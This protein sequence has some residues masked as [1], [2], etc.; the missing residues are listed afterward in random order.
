M[1]HAHQDKKG[2]RT[3]IPESFCSTWNVR[4]SP[5]SL[6]ALSDSP[7]VGRSIAPPQSRRRED[8][9]LAGID[10]R[11][12][13]A[14]PAA[15]SSRRRTPDS[16]ASRPESPASRLHRLSRVGQVLTI[17]NT[18]GPT[19]LAGSPTAVEWTIRP[20]FSACSSRNRTASRDLRPESRAREIDASAARTEKGCKANREWIRAC[21]HETH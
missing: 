21:R 1:I 20:A 11:A 12:R 19:S 6:S 4:V 2:I 18:G 5:T 13:S 7:I 9:S 16:S 10:Q 17:P 14:H 15:S 3:G 8:P